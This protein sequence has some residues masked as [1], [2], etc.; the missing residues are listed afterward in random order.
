MLQQQ[1]PF[2]AK[3]AE[4]S[5]KSGANVVDSGDKT[6][7][8]RASEWGSSEVVDWMSMKKSNANI[9]DNRGISEFRHRFQTQKNSEK[10]ARDLASGK[11]NPQTLLGF[12]S[13]AAE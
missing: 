13:A 4:T 7:L 8:M 2:A 3:R 11:G 9:V 5:F 12:D 6:P 10:S 1:T